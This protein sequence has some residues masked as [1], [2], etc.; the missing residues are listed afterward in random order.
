MIMVN[1]AAFASNVID[2]HG[3]LGRAWLQQLPEIIVTYAQRWSLKVL[4]PFKQLSYHYVAPAIQADGSPAVLK[5]G[6]PHLELSREIE[7]LR[8]FGGNGMARLLQ[9]DPQAGIFLEERLL[10]GTPLAG[11]L[12]GQEG[13]EQIV[14][15]ATQ[16]MQRLWKPAPT[17]RRFATLEEWASDLNSLHTA[18][19]GAYGPFP[20]ELV[21]QAHYRFA[22]LIIPT[23]QSWL[24]HG[25]LHMENILKSDRDVWLAIDPKG[26]VGAR[27]WDIATLLCDM[28]EGM[29]DRDLKNRLE[30]RSALLAEL[31]GFERQHIL[32]WSLAQMV[33]RGWWSYEDHGGGWQAAFHIADLTNSLLNP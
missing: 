28:P 30:R 26:V 22:E 15:I 12:A 18:F 20:V 19:G 7:A 21:E 23:A 5:A 14:R 33:L 6:V 32:S 1:P 3:E 29:C 4:P 2:I 13:D 16:V 27:E 31:L 10:P 8:E 11:L 25:D 9:A 24:I 17:G